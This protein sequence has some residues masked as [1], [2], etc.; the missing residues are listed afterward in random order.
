V[1]VGYYNGGDIGVL[2]DDSRPDGADRVDDALDAVANALQA[3]PYFTRFT[4]LTFRRPQ[5]TVEPKPDAHG[6]QVWGFLQQRLYTLDAPGV[7]ALRSS[8]SMDIVAPGVCKRAVTDRVRQ[9][10]GAAPD[11]PVL[12]IGDRGRWPGNDF[13]LLSGPHSLSVDEVSPD[14]GSCWNLAVPG[15]GRYDRLS[16]ATRVDRSWSPI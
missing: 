2:D 5:I 10:L 7:V 1:V 16:H 13:S 4:K 3:E 11:H 15:S 8:H 6:E 14:A 12:C 9:V